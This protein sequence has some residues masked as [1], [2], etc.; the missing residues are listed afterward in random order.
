MQAT[1]SDTALAINLS[2]VHIGDYRL[3]E[4]LKQIF[5]EGAIPPQSVIFEITETAA[6][7]NLSHAKEFMEPLWALGCRFALDDFGV[8]FTSFAQLRVLPVD[9]V[10]I[11]GIFVRNVLESK[12]DQALVKAIIDIAHSLDKPVVAECIETEAVLQWLGQHGV[13]YNQSSRNR[14]FDD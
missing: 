1:Y 9:F 10:K 4:W 5:N 11:D 8:G 2:A 12:E 3:F 6:L 7:K 13:D 14:K